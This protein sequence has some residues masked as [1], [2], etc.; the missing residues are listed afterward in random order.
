MSDQVL[1]TTSKLVSL[2]DSVR[3]HASLSD[4]L[5][6][7][8]MPGLIGRG[9]ESSLEPGVYD[10]N[11]AMLKSWDQLLADEDIT[12][13]PSQDGYTFN[14]GTFGFP[15]GTRHLVIAPGVTDFGMNGT[16]SDTGI[17]TV[18]LPKSVWKISRNAFKNAR[19]LTSITMP[20]VT[21]IQDNAFD[22]CAF[23]S[24]VLPDGLTNIGK[25]IFRAC[26]NLTE[27][28]I[29]NSVKNIDS[30]AFYGVWNLTTIH[31]SGTLEG[32]PWGAD[33]SVTVVP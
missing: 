15:M 19:A 17:Y 28:T 14:R 6:L 16:N 24:I 29:P 18:T 3:S 25:E 13:K 8:D 22:T 27:I 31:Y 21:T 2:A 23:K 4:L 10:E 32:A 7:P 11:Y 5:K 20:G 26:S 33:S 30:R 1:I 12:V 9:Y